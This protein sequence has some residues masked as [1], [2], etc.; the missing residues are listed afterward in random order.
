MAPTPG[1]CGSP[2]SGDYITDIS[3]SN[4][5][6]IIIIN[7]HVTIIFNNNVTTNNINIIVINII[8]TTGV[9]VLGAIIIHTT[10]GVNNNHTQM[11]GVYG[12]FDP[13]QGIGLHLQRSCRGRY[14][15]VAVV[16]PLIVGLLPF[17]VVILL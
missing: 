16:L 11:Q 9:T 10:F 15:C 14:H 7:T 3:A 8:L 6:T 4:N 1:W 12:P 13:V 17:L 5:M 2:R